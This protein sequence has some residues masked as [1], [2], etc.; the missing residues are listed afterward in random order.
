MGHKPT[1][2]RD[3][4]KIRFEEFRLQAAVKCNNYFTCNL[5]TLTKILGLLFLEWLWHVVSLFLCTEYFFFRCV[6]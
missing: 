4:V 1:L 5:Q 3:A 2:R 6:L